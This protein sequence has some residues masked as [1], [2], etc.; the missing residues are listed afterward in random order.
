MITETTKYGKG[1]E[2]PHGLEEDQYYELMYEFVDLAKVKGL[3]VRQAQKLFTDCADMVLDVKTTGANN[4][5]S[6]NG[7]DIIKYLGSIAYSL[8]YLV[9]NDKRTI[10]KSH[11]IPD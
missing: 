2:T 11:S 7:K 5:D 8:D 1:Y 9:F 6:N 3:T 4:I 10:D